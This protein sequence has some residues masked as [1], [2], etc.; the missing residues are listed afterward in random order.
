MLSNT[1]DVLP[2][3]SDKCAIYMAEGVADQI[4]ELHVGSGGFT[5]I[6]LPFE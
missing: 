4:H 2:Y 5:T 3:Y 1:S 6:L